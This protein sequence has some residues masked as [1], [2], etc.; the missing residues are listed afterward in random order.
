MD[1]LVLGLIQLIDLFL[2]IGHEL[3][4]LILLLLQTIAQLLEL[5]MFLDLTL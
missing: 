5:L 2:Q 4:H 3:I 1:G